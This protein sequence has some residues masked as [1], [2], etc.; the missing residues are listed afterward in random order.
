MKISIVILH[1]GDLAVTQA[2]IASLVRFEKNNFD[3][4]IVNNMQQLLSKKDFPAVTS[5]KI[6]NNTKN[7]GFA[8]GVN[9]GIKHALKNKANYVLLLNNDTLLT[10]PIVKKL[11]HV[12]STDD[13]IGI[14]SPILRFKKDGRKLLDFGGDIN[15]SIGRTF[16]EE[17][18]KIYTH[19]TIYPIYV[20]GCCMLIKRE[21]FE[22][23]GLFDESF[24]LYYEDVDFCLR[25]R[26]KGWNATI[27]PSVIVDHALSKSAGKVSFIA[28]YH[29]IRSAIIFVK[30]YCTKPL[31]RLGNICF[32]F[33]Q[34]LLFVKANPI[35]ALGGIKALSTFVIKTK[36]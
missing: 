25:M 17:G 24:F 29:Q 35:G 7:V 6:I 26:E 3:L 31:Q 5:L 18:E 33:F 8:T 22:K 36:Q 1:F 32:I 23:T 10:Q 16:H 11:L 19:K 30:K 28:T 14:T 13:T 21:V 9:I 34:A 27:T 4:V 20:S 15:L 2:C 12:F